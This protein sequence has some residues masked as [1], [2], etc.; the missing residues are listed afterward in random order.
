MAEKL[1]RFGLNNVYYAVVTDTET[2]TYDTPVAFPG[3]VSLSLEPSGDSSQ[4]WADNIK[5]ATFSTNG[6]YSGTMEMAAATDQV[7]IDLL[8]YIQDENGMLIEPTDA[9]TVYFALMFEV[10]GN[11]RGQRSVLYN[12]S[13]ARPS[14]NANTK[15]DSTDP[16]TIELE[17]EASSVDFDVAGE[18]RNIVMATLENTTDTADAYSAWFDEVT[19]P[20][21]SE[22]EEST[23]ETT[24]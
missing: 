8:G 7:L 19:I 15:T 11:I 24:D 9:S 23:E 12:C 20:T 16:D 10:S 2:Q 3:A 21:S 6:G 18:T 13:L 1:V 22:E 5:Y 4:F 14:R 17:F